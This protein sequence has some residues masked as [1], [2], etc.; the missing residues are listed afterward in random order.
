MLERLLLAIAVTFSVYLS[1][2]SGF[3]KTP[4]PSAIPSVLQVPTLPEQ[5]LGPWQ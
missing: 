2:D 3:D 1:V 5:P 4:I